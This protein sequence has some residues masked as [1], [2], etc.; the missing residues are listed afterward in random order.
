MG[1]QIQ[2]DTGNVIATKGTYSG[3]VSIGGTL[4]YEDV[5]NIDSVGLITSRTGLEIGARPGIAASISVD[6]NAI[7]SGITTIGGVINASSNIKV[8]SGITLS[9]EGNSFITGVSTSNGGLVVGNGRVRVTGPS[10]ITNNTQT[11]VAVDSADDNT[12]G[13]GGKI[14]FA[15]LVNGTVRT[16]AAVGALKE[17][18]GTGNFAGDLALYT[19]RNNEGSLD[20]RV[21]I[22]SA[23]G[24]VGIGT[25][26]PVSR[27]DV[28][29]A[30]IANGSFYHETAG[31]T[32]GAQTQDKTVTFNQR[33]VFLMLISFSLGTTT[34]DFSRNIYSLGLFTS[35]SDGATW[36]AIQQDLNSSHVGNFTISDGGSA[37]QL[38][39]QKS[40]GSDSRACAFRI[41][42]LSSA[43]VQIT[44]TDT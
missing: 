14:G 7:F 21:R 37:G 26:N 33:G 10:T 43:N 30:I 18:D 41:D 19:R 11:I 22:K 13:L 5:T 31:Q 40:S 16:F 3:D 29:G 25:T 17:I 38:R 2:G 20:E 42:V 27:L 6:G 15:G 8:G 35:R 44:V 32:N 34:S 1:V 12:A 23:G 4:T 39:I 36:T 24:K 9:P 28:K